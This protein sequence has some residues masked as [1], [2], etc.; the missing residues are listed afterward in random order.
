[1]QF[2]SDGKYGYGEATTNSFYGATIAN[3]SSAIESVR[4]IVEADRS[5][6][7]CS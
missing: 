2:E 6:I 7:R 5:T 3:M 1:M 4:P